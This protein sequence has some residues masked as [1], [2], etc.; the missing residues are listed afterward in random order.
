MKFSGGESTRFGFVPHE[1]YPG[2][3]L[4][5][6]CSGRP[7]KQN[8][9]KGEKSKRKGFLRRLIERFSSGQRHV[10]E[11]VLDSTVEERRIIAGLYW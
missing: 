4:L 10:E 11:N 9:D 3:E 1:R 5:A 2:F 7:W 6:S 8:S